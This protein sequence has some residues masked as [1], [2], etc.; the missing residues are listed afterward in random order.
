MTHLAAA[1]ELVPLRDS[2]GYRNWLAGAWLGALLIAGSA[3]FASSYPAHLHRASPAVPAFQP[4]IC[5][6]DVLVPV[7]NFAQ[8]AWIP[9]GTAAL[10][11]SW[12]LTAAGWILTTAI[13]AGLANALKPD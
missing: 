10:A 5:T 3:V 11:P 4:V 9:Q 8:Q 2:R 6:L 7:V 12:L 1:P 13:A